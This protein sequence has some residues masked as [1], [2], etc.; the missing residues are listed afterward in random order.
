M[1]EEKLYDIPLRKS[2]SESGR[3]KKAPHAIKAVRDFIAKKT[4]SENIILGSGV[5]EL[6]WA[7]GVS[8]PPSKI[9]VKVKKDGDKVFADLI[10]TEVRKEAAT[11]EKKE[12]ADKNSEQPK[13]GEQK[14]V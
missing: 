9:R 6:I 10:T 14:K 7:R 2:F 3:R 11:E 5:N 12:A 13:Q 4:R 1:T 8:H